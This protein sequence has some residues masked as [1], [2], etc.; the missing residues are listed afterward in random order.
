[1]ND[2]MVAFAKDNRGKRILS[3]FM[4]L[5]LTLGLFP[6]YGVETLAAS[7]SPPQTIKLKAADFETGFKTYQ[8]PNGLGSCMIHTFKMDAGQEVYGFCYDHTKHMG[9]SLVGQT[10]TYDTNIDAGDASGYAFIPFLDWWTY[11]SNVSQDIDAKYPNLSDSDKKGKDQWYLTEWDRLW[12][13][14]WV[15]A[16]IWLNRA[17]KFTD[18][19]NAEQIKMVAKERDAVLR[20]YGV[21][22]D[23]TEWTSERLL[24]IYISNWEAG[25]FGQRNYYLYNPPGSSIQPVL[26]P[27]IENTPDVG[28]AFGYVKALKHDANG[29][30]IANVEFT[31]YDKN[32]SYVDSFRT[33]T[34]GWGYKMVEFGLGKTAEQ[35]YVKETKVPSTKYVMDTAEYPVT[36]DSSKNNTPET[37]ALVNGGAPVVNQIKKTTP[38]T[39][40]I[41]KV[42]A[43]TGE[44]IGPAT[45]HLEGSASDGSYISKDLSCDASGS[46]NVQ[47]SDPN[48]A[49]YIKPGEYTV[50]ETVAPAGY[51]KTDEA[52]HLSLKLEEIDGEWVAT[53]SGPLVFENNKK[54]EIIIQKVSTDS[55]P[56]AGAYFDLYRN[57]AKVTSLGPTGNDGT[58]TYNGNGDG[59]A[60]G[61]YEIVETQ[62]PAGYLI[63]WIHSQSFFVNAE[64][65]DTTSQKVTFMDAEYPEIIIRK[66]AKGKTDVLAGAKFEVQIDGKNLGS[67]VTGYDGAVKIDYATYGQYL[68]AD[69]NSWTVSVREVQAPDG[70]ILDD[71]NWQ[72]A[73]LQ[74]GETLKEFAFEDTK[75]PTIQILKQAT[76]TNQPLAGATFE[77]TIDGEAAGEYTTDAAG[78]IT[79]DYAT[80]GRFLPTETTN[81]SWTVGVRELTPP[82]GYIIDNADWQ[83]QE[84]SLGQ[85]LATF[86]FTDTK[87]PKI[88]ILKYADGTTT[89]LPGATFQVKIDGT[90]VG[91][92]KTDAAGLIE[93]DY[94]TYGRYLPKEKTNQSWT[95]SVKETQAPDGYILNDTEQSQ[96]M[97]IGEDVKEFTFNNTKYPD[98]LIRKYADGTMTPLAGATFE[99]RIDAQTIGSF[100]TDANGTIRI[101]Y[102][103]YGEFLKNSESKKSWTVGVRETVAPD[104]YILNDGEW[105]DQELKLGEVLKEFTFVDTKYPKIIIR[106]FA[107]GTTTPLAGATFEVAIDAQ[108]VGSYQTDDEGKIVIDYATYERFL[109]LNEG[110]QSWTVSVRETQAPDGYILNDANWHNQELKLG[111]ALKEFTFVDTKYPEI[112]I[113]KLEEGTNKPLAGATFEVRIDEQGI[114]SYQTDAEGKIVIDYETYRRYLNLTENKQ[115]WTISVRETVAPDGYIL[116]DK[117]WHSQEMK[118][119]ESLKEFTFT[120]TKY[121]VI[122]ITKVDKETGEPLA[123]TSFRIVINGTSFMAEKRTDENGEI[124]ITYDEYGRFLQDKNPPTADGWTVTVTETE[125]PEGYNKDKQEATGDYTQTQLL[126]YGQDLATFEFKD[127]SF[128]A[129][130][131]I[132]RDKETGWALAGA[133]FTLKS[134]SLDDPKKGTISREGQ[135]DENGRLL[136]PELPNGTYEV[137][138]TVPPTGYQLTN[139]VKQT[140]IVTS[141]S[142][143]IIEVQFNN[144]PKEGLLI[145]KQDSV[146][147]QALAGTEFSVQYLGAV[148]AEDGTTNDPRNYITNENGLIYIP[149]LKAGWYRIQEIAV[150]DGYVLETEP[151]LV[152]VVNTHVPVTVTFKNYQDG[153]LVILKKDSQTGLPLPGALFKITTAGGNFIKTIETGANGYATLN[154]L[155]PGSYV[156]T[157]VE[158]PDGHIIDPTPQTFELR[159]G[160]T[161]PVFL[162]FYN[163][164]KTNI[165]VRKEDAQTHIGL[166]GAVFQ[167]TKTDGTVIADRLVTGED[168][169]AALTDLLPGSYVVKEIEAPLGYILNSSAQTI[170]IDVGETRTVLFRNNKPGGIAILKT[171]AISGLPLQN[172]EFDIFTTDDKLVGHYTTDKDGYIRISDLTAGYYFVQETAAPEGYLLDETRHKVEVKD[173]QV[174]QVNLKNYEKSGLTIYKIDKDSKLPLSGAVFGI[175]DMHGSLIQSVTT[176][177]SGTAGIN[178]L[179]PGWYRVKELNAPL[180]YVLDTEEQ[181]VEIVDGKPATVTVTNIPQTGITVKKIDAASKEPLAG[182]VFE[183]RTADDKMIDTYTT[184][185]SG[186]FVTQKVDAGTYF[187]VETKAPDGYAIGDEAQTKVTVTEGTMPVVTIE[188]HKTTTIQIQKTDAVTGAYL[189]GAEFE[190]W[191]LNCTKLLGTYVTD[192]TG[193]VYSDPLPAGN[194]IVKESKAPAGYALDETHHHVNLTYDHPYILKVS[195]QPLTAIMITKVSTE[196]D[197]PLMGAKF[198]V[199]TAE[200]KV[201]GE[202]TTDTTGTTTTQVLEPGVYYVQEVEA[203][204]GYLI[205]DKVFKVTLTAGSTAPLVVEDTP[206]PSLVIF[207]GD[208]NTKKG[209]AGAVF[210]VE[211]ADHDFIGTYTTDAQG[212]AIIRP[213]NPGHYIVTEMSAPEGY[214]VSETP[215]TITVKAGVVNRVEFMDA[216]KG[217]L[218]IRLEDQADGKKLENGHFEL[219][220]AETG[221]KTAEGVTDNSGSIVWGNLTPGRYIIKHTFAPD[222]YTI[223]DEVK[224][225]IVVAGDT[226]IVVF[227]D[228]TAGLVIEKLDKL[229]S[230]PLAGARFQVTRNSDNIVIGEYVTDNDGLALV[231]GLI[232]GMYTVE[233]LVAPSGY[234]IDTASQLTHVKA[235]EQAHVTFT[236]TPF[237]GITISAVD[238]DNN[239]PLSGVVIEVWHQNG[240]LANSYTT[241]STGTVQ[242]DKLAFGYY[243]LKVIKVENGYTAVTSEQTVEIK[244][245]IAVS[246]KFEFVARG[247]LQIYALNKDEQGLPGMKVTVTKQNG[248]FVGNYTADNTGLIKVP[249]LEAGWYVVTEVTAPN[250]YTITGENHQ[251]I[252]ITSNGDSVLKFYHGKTYGVQ[253]RTSV[254]Q[255]GEMVAGVKYEITDLNGTR[256]SSYVSDATGLIYATLEPGWYI[257]KQVELPDGYKN[258]TLCSSRNVEV[259]ADIPTIID[260][261]LSQLSSIRVKFVDGTTNAPLYGVRAVLKDGGGTIIDEYT[262]NNEGY[263][264]LKQSIVNGTYTL[265]QIS[266]PSGYTVDS[267]PK[268]ID[269]LNGETTEIVWKMYT[270]AGQI[271]VHVTSSAYNSTLDLAAGSNLQGAT[272]EIYDPFTYAVLSTITSDSYGVAASSGLPI[273]RYIIREKDAAPYFGLSGKETEVYIKINNDVVRVEYQE[274]PLALKTTHTVKANQN[275]SAGTS[276][277][278]IFTAVNNESS[279]RLDNFYWNIKVPTDAM[280][281]GTLYTGKWSSSVF[282]SISYKTNMNDYRPLASNL[283]SSSAY[284]YDLS[285]LAINVQ[286]G[287]YVTDIRFEFGTVPANFKP[288]VSPVFFGYVMPNV[289]NGY[290]VILRSECGGKYGESW[291]TAS[292]L[293]TTNVVS[294]NKS[295]GAGWYPSSGTGTGTTWPSTLPKTG[296]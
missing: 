277:K 125:M 58:I 22:V 69:K 203:P 97:T 4:A 100:Q 32:K 288:N 38:P 107:E 256:I 252:E 279:Q 26:I 184:D 272:F 94:E 67:Y 170:A 153:Q 48:A 120:D 186:S 128:R 126:K 257:I 21:T 183:L 132:K 129:I 172:A 56:L 290:K 77:V 109:K 173:F 225:V 140:I 202:Y 220:F 291:S 115:T 235:G 123:N 112:L 287:E 275:V 88:R 23:T 213:I 150:P 276:M 2:L 28:D 169:L 33:G 233:E 75:Y 198:Q 159:K 181:L 171:D 10:W 24:N 190:V 283:N 221:T 270:Q 208:S 195:D 232:P 280:R 81:K 180:G 46:L 188:N 119:G 264:I 142:D 197:T 41:S 160:Q 189:P 191:T 130:E 239:K 1:M 40:T 122:R 101:D 63:P 137:T 187:L 265:E 271:Q 167:V 45:F 31:I 12:T 266:V 143:N 215:K 278:Y 135:T 263:I 66:Y 6:V 194:Y 55:K 154:G 144:A 204:D 118:L 124:T 177:T 65:T 51:E 16:A 30:P 20:A 34:D 84:V 282:Y 151:R 78:K 222:G 199:K 262:S 133:T 210:K 60:S 261:Q 207:K 82:D 248:E 246:V 9:T 108:T 50:T 85:D 157:E 205:N 193:M 292:A 74:Q 200:G 284:Q 196:D 219:I 3:L 7:G 111:E 251:S 217:A 243:V 102:T 29:Q 242:T 152:E 165:Y 39:G 92:F 147:G 240:E 117:D 79:L 176:N 174:T 260:F 134:I 47:W 44:G 73:E 89:P 164:G 83:Y 231:S 294:N 229:T 285:S 70:Y 286:G 226:K 223:V 237:A 95:V 168:G 149:D 212:E 175:Y 49:S 296:Y 43:A 17:G 27:E 249:N 106:K 98:I 273:G 96:E 121:P 158:A 267:V 53:S 228:C 145:R 14:A 185:A 255:T 57:G 99:V 71:D 206:A 110:K 179:Q 241:D 218:I 250:G 5:V 234:A 209:I 36:V 274:A 116:D 247:I 72:T 25:A 236:D 76:G 178:G 139:P 245:G 162:I 214:Q 80:Y 87:Y 86:T 192:K 289:V 91:S 127:T 141:D 54:H 269:V 244:D 155:Q 103:T 146:T 105:H 113:R 161:E 259:K 148:S 258:Y 64:D 216:E 18:Y 90:D 163:D 131:V 114:G 15:Q 104:G 227:Q 68:S 52:K 19:K 11:C 156:V 37:A 201:V 293:W 268:T 211:T 230:E 8:S 42:D 182:A 254:K 138:E 281:A 166:E 295:T 224:D 253:I 238:K 61:Y 13:N 93:I 59:V 136:F 62:A 35:F